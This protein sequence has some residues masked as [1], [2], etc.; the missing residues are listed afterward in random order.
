MNHEI[1]FCCSAETI[2][3]PKGVGLK[4]LPVPELEPMPPWTQIKSVEDLRAVTKT[5]LANPD[6]LK[7]CLEAESRILEEF[8]PDLVVS[9]LR[10][11]TGVAASSLGIPSL[12]IHNTKLFLYPLSEVIPMVLDTLHDIGVEERDAAKIFGDVLVVP[13]FSMFEPLSTIPEPMLKII[14]GSVREIFY[15]G[16]LLRSNPSDLPAKL[17]LKRQ[18]GHVE[19]P[20]VFITFGGS[21]TGAEYLKKVLAGLMG[22][23]AHFVIITGHN[24]AAD[25]L[26]PLADQLKIAA[27]RSVVS[28][29]EYTDHSLAFMK[30]ADVA[31]IHGGHGTTMEGIMCGTPLIIIPH[32]KEQEENGLRSVNLGTGTLLKPQNIESEVMPAVQH[33]LTDSQVNGAL[34][35]TA[36]T[37]KDFNGSKQL[38]DFIQN[39]VWMRQFRV[40]GVEV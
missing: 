5:R 31:I 40:E 20:L 7:R 34:H 13:D 18:Y 28:L 10:N 12:S 25:A 9:D 16:P 6:F 2:H 23:E 3:I 37:F 30:A 24:V 8:K 14:M 19:L 29:F 1:V 11:T 39:Q 26:L 36:H 33:L 22:L 4:C 15:S 27:P 32:N 38:A 21:P 17:E 35:Q